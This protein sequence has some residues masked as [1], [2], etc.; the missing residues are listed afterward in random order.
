[1]DIMLDLETMGTSP[2]AAIIAI[3]A[4]TMDFETGDI[5]E[6]F[7]KKI[8]LSSA[9]ESGGIIDPDTVLWWLA[10]ND[11]ARFEFIA[12]NNGQALSLYAELSQF[13]A[14]IKTISD[15]KTVRIWGN[16]SDFDNVIL[17]DSY[18]RIKM[19]IPWKFYN[20]RCYRT[21]KNLYPEIKLVRSG[22]AHNALDDAITQAKHLIAIMQL[23]NQAD[24]LKKADKPA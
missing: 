9:V 13:E 5:G 23:I 22:T 6:T 18:R 19:D 7:Y 15:P 2:A 24:T 4:C 17:G 3:G 8:T 14:W 10:Q 11:A 1:M 21:V 16:G 20:N 12:G